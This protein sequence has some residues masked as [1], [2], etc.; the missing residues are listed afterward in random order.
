MS[1]VCILKNPLKYVLKYHLTLNRHLQLL[2]TSWKILCQ[3]M[4]MVGAVQLGYS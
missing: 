2:A 1:Q 3:I 4:K